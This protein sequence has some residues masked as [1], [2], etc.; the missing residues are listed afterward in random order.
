[1]AKWTAFPHVG[2]YAFDGKSLKKH[3][4]RLHAGDFLDAARNEARELGDLAGTAVI[5]DKD[6]AHRGDP[7][8]FAR[9]GLVASGPLR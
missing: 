1:M 7:P 3:W 6:F 2:D 9:P 4:A 8:E 5:K